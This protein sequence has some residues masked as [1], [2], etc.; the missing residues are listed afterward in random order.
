MSKSNIQTTSIH[1]GEKEKHIATS[2][3]TSLISSLIDSNEERSVSFSRK[4]SPT[5][6]GPKEVLSTSGS[7]KKSSKSKM[8]VQEI[9]AFGTSPA[10]FSFL[11]PNEF[12]S[13]KETEQNK[14]VQVETRS[15]KSEQVRASLSRCH[16]TSTLNDIKKTMDGFVH[17]QK[18][19]HSR[20][21]SESSENNSLASSVQQKD[22]ICETGNEPA[23]PEMDET[24]KA[25]YRRC[26]SLKS[27]KTPPGTPGRRK[28]VR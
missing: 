20:F 1:I 19:S 8:T 7:E 25:K 11:L 21:V 4:I 24:N 15:D 14:N 23:T 3:L 26:S 2:K 16:S 22:L 27:G 6:G 13:N 18:S 10:N 12:S 5:S 9:P 28:I 17:N